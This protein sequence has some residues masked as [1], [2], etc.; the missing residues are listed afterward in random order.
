VEVGVGAIECAV[1]RLPRADARHRIEHCSV[2]GSRTLRKLAGL[3]GAVVTQPAF[4]FHEGDRYLETVPQDRLPH[5][6]PLNAM[7]KSGLTTGAGSDAPLADPNPMVS[8]G[9]AVTRNSKAGQCLPGEGIGLM[10][11]IRMHTL[12]AAWV[13]FEEQI[14]GSITPGKLADFVVLDES[15]FAVPQNRLG[16]IRVLMTVLGGS[17]AWRDP[18]TSLH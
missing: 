8:V 11:A 12:G 4:L 3:G 17:V 6:Y 10:Q 5:L 14:K 18:D 16:H 2:C 1:R 15:P 9:A 13:N 7:I